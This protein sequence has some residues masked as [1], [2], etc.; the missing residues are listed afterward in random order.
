ML[1]NLCCP[2]SGLRCSEDVFLGP[3]PKTGYPSVDRYRLNNASLVAPGISR[4]PLCE[5]NLP[6]DT[7]NSEP[8]WKNI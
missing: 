1:F 7:L 5:R 2:I 6:K 8:A 4:G 3:Y